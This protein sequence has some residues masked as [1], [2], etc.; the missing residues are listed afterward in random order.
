VL[1]VKNEM[2]HGTHPERRVAFFPSYW[3]KSSFPCYTTYNEDAL[4]FETREANLP[5]GE[6]G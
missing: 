3:G 2:A 4:V 6:T 1:L 5:Q